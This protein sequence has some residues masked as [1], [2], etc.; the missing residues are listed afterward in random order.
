MVKDRKVLALLSGGVD[1]TVLA[2]LLTKALGRLYFF[3]IQY[4]SGISTVL[5]LFAASLHSAHG[6]IHPGQKLKL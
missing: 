3:K 4:F 5:N 6:P 1:S 2:A